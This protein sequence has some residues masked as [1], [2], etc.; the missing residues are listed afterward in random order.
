MRGGVKRKCVFILRGSLAATVHIVAVL[1][2]CGHSRPMRVGQSLELGFVNVELLEPDA[3][4]ALNRFFNVF[5]FIAYYKRMK[6][7]FSSVL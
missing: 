7:L 4:L 1:P 5:A 6:V 3:I 2:P